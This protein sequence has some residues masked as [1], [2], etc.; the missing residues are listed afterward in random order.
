[1][2]KFETAYSALKEPLDE[3]EIDD[4]PSD[5]ST[6]RSKVATSAGSKFNRLYALSRAPS[7]PHV[8]VTDSNGTRVYLRMK[9]SQQPQKKNTSSRFQLLSVPISDLRETVEEEASVWFMCLTVPCRT[10]LCCSIE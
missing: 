2:D 7:G 8:T 1:M 6:Q 5:L 10:L 3:E 4:L 9:S